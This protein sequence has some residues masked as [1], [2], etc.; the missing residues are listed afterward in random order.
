MLEEA[1]R[2][3]LI[4][5]SLEA[6][7]VLTRERRG[8]G[9]PLQANLAELPALFIVSQVELAKEPTERRCA[10]PPRSPARGISGS[11][12]RKADGGKCPRCWTYAP[13][14]AA[15]AEVCPKCQE[16]LS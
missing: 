13:E 11:R 5:A 8:A 2:E 4:G 6:R 12:I 7:V 16:A 1:R 15:G 10:P 3:K 14:V 9:V